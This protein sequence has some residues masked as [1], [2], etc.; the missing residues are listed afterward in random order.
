MDQVRAKF[1]V[2]SIEVSGE[3]KV[4]K[5]SACTTTDGDGKDFTP[6]TPYGE[7]T[8]GINGDVPAANFFEKDKVY[9]MDFSE[10]TQ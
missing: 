2:D 9:H 3:N 8:I 6:Y 10:A 4:V 1:Q 5:M 7:L